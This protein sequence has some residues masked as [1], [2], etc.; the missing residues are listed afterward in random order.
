M[1]ALRR[2]IVLGLVMPLL[3]G[4]FYLELGTPAASSDPKAKGA[5]VLAHFIGCHEPE[6]GVLTATAE[7]VV[8]GKRQTIALTAVALGKP[9]L[10]AIS[11]QWPVDGKWVLRLVGRHPQ[12]AVVT[13]T[14]VKVSGEGF[15]RGSAVMKIGSLE[16]DAVEALLR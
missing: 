13:N 11:R 16:A 3:G 9:G 12:L 5:V 1:K 6:K 15:D 14:P 2:L 10:F 7:G 4:G 8:G